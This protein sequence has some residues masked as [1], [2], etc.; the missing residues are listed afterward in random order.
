MCIVTVHSYILVGRF[1]AC[2][3]ICLH[4]CTKGAPINEHCVLQTQQ[5]SCAAAESHE[6]A[7]LRM[8]Q[9]N[10]NKYIA[11]LYNRWILLLST[12][13]FLVE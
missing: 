11:Y 6:V 12:F 13:P 9:V 7:V 8:A 3:K 2:M 5:M 1:H 10:S 4:E